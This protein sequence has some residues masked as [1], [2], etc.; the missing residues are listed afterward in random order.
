MISNA[1]YNLE[2]THQ[3]H[4]NLFSSIILVPAINLKFYIQFSFRVDQLGIAFLQQFYDSQK[5]RLLRISVFQTEVRL[6]RVQLMELPQK[7]KAMLGQPWV[8]TLCHQPFGMYKHLSGVT[9]ALVILLQSV[10]YSSLWL[11]LR[12]KIL[13]DFILLFSAKY[14]I[15]LPWSTYKK[16][17]CPS[18]C[19]SVYRL[20]EQIHRFTLCILL[21]YFATISGS[22]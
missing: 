9:S 5:S 16:L 6:R 8:I 13:L 17:S 21:R 15:F 12:L 3:L 19:Q 1:N 18:Q 20:P 11:L 10:T 22:L 7:F 2:H 14:T 4:S